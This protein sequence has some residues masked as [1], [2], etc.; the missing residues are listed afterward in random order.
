MPLQARSVTKRRKLNDAQRHPCE[1][2]AIT[3][4]QTCSEQAPA[5]S[6]YQTAKPTTGKKCLCSIRSWRIAFAINNRKHSRLSAMFPYAL[7]T[8]QEVDLPRV[9]GFGDSVTQY[10]FDGLR[11]GWLAQV[12]SECMIYAELHSAVVL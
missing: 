1:H 6:R 12:T 8:V 3:H 2:L 9:I 5:H 11:Q 4:I 10:A 7:Q